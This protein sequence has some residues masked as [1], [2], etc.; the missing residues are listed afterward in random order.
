M[1]ENSYDE[2]EENKF[3]FIDDINESEIDQALSS[4][5][6]ASNI[7]LFPSVIGIG[8][9]SLAILGGAGIY[10]LAGLA[11]YFGFG[12]FTAASTFGISTGGI[13]FALV[14]VGVGLAFLVNHFDKKKSE[15]SVNKKDIKSFEDKLKDPNSKERE[16][17]NNF[18][19]DLNKYL[20]KKIIILIKSEHDELMKIASKI[21]LLPQN[22]VNILAKKLLTKV[23]ERVSKFHELDKF[24]ILVLGKSGVG[25]TTLI[26]AILGQEQNGT[27]I[28]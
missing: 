9:G 16:F 14:G 24:S 15:K 12:T 8:G 2:K 26:N 19:K 23:R 10:G 25:K 6:L 22:L 28:G 13:G 18:S 21:E 17:Y 1:E 4:Y 7:T 27:T 20:N 5:E 3:K 11:S